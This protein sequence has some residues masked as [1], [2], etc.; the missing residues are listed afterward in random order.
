MPALRPTAYAS[1]R[2][3]TQSFGRSWRSAPDRALRPGPPPAAL[4]QRSP[5]SVSAYRPARWSAWSAKAARANPRWA[6]LCSDSSRR[7]LGRFGSTVRTS[8]MLPAAVPGQVVVRSPSGAV[9]AG[10]SVRRGGVAPT[11]RRSR[12]T[13]RARWGPAGLRPSRCSDLGCR[14][15]TGRSRCVAGAGFAAVCSRP[16]RCHRRH[17][18][19][20]TRRAPWSRIR[21]SPRRGRGYRGRIVRSGR[22]SRRR[23]RRRCSRSARGRMSRSGAPRR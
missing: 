23:W 5:T 21:R 10:L 20:C 7:R 17:S 6:T 14:D 11:G 19:G 18:W 8:A 15:G 4:P 16:S 9:V 3:D 22:G 12:R 13:C 2:F 1:R